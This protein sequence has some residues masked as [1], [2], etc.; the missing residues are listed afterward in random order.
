MKK[1]IVMFVKNTVSVLVLSIFSF[2]FSVQKSLAAF[3]I[4]ADSNGNI[5]A[6]YGSNNSVF[7]SMGN[8][9]GWNLG[10]SYGLPQGSLLGIITNL[11]YWLLALF[12]IGGIIAFVIAG[13]FYL[14]AGA[15]KANADK[16]KTG[17]V[18]A[19]IGIIVGL[20]GF[21]IL[22]AVSAFLGGSKTF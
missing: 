9:G 21:L 3:G 20:S 22:Q 10:Y 17:M 19:I 5:S 14:L 7:N 2:V 11:L 15:D 6:V 13:I 16:G 8:S 18:N 1:V 4:G 12:A